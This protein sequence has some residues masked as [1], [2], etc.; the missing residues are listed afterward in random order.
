MGLKFD[1]VGGGQ[2]KQVVAQIIEAEKQ[3][4]KQL[5]ARKKIE[6]SK[7]K[8]FQEFKSKFTGFEKTLNEFSNF[9]KFRELK[10]DLGDGTDILSVTVDKE[11]AEPGTYSLTVDSLAT[12][13]SAISN[14]FETMLSEIV[15]LSRRE[16]T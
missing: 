4:L 2:F 15:K 1:P 6:D 8:L 12:R 9:R 7:M 16:P 11:R 5:E 3:P 14:G 13:T 10:V